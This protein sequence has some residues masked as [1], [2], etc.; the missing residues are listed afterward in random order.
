[1]VQQEKCH[2][3]KITQNDATSIVYIQVQVHSFILK[4]KINTNSNNNYNL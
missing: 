2:D 1:M 3:K 4:F